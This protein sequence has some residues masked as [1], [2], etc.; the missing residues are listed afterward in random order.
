M[1]QQ[2]IWQAIARHRELALGLTFVGVA[3]WEL[4]EFMALE[5]PHGGA[6][7]LPLALHSVQIALVLIVTWTVIRAWQARSRYE[8]ALAR[9]VEQATMAQEEER[10]RIAYDVHDGIAQLIVSAKQHVDTARDLAD[11]APARARHEL[12]RAGQRLEAAVVETRRVL[13]A[14][15]PSAVDSLGL[16]DAMRRALEEAAG[17]AGWASRFVDELGDTPVPPAVETAAFRILQ[18]SLLNAAR[19]AKST[20]VEVDLGRRPGWLRLEVRDDGVGLC[21]GAGSGRGLGLAGMRERARLLGGTCRIEAR[22]G[23]GTAVCV[24]LPL[25]PESRRAAGDG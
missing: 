18:E 8:D 6:G 3:G 19:H 21:P 25:G 12:G 2:A 14:L 22:A 13:R 23:G 4:V 11:G 9:M 16:A 15:R 17:D 10:R 7:P 5:R 20:R 1:L 24:A